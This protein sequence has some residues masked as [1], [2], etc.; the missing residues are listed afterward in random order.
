[1]RQRF[2]HYA[3]MRSMG[4]I[5]VMILALGALAPTQSALASSATYPGTMSISGSGTCSGVATGNAI[6]VAFTITRLAIPI[7]NENMYGIIELHILANPG[8]GETYIAPSP[9][10]SLA[11]GESGTT[12]GTYTPSASEAALLA[13]T[14]TV[15][16]P[17]SLAAVVTAPGEDTWI[18]T[19]DGSVVITGCQD[20]PTATPVTP[21]ATNTVAPTATNT[22]V[23]TATN[24][25]APTSTSTAV[26]TSTNT[27]A[28]T[29]TNTA[30]PTATNTIVPTA[31][32]TIVPTETNTVAPTATTPS[33]TPTTEPTTPGETSTPEPTTPG[34]TP[35]A[36]L[37]P[38][39]TPVVPTAVPT[40]P[41]KPG[42][43]GSTA[44]PV[45]V[46]DLP[47]T[48]QGNAGGP[49]DHLAVALVIGAVILG[50]AGF[51]YGRRSRTN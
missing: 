32:N 31:T 3:F 33:E 4:V 39:A 22:T 46:T 7:P 11:V 1:M 26:P 29:A 47:T 9:L 34:E 10:L 24:T 17:V 28:A 36:T 13:A 40:K 19:G 16:I 30:V 37:P 12:Y 20:M 44:N 35:T 2:G 23:P 41:S 14:G 38:A 6:P 8:V 25:V 5:V 42:Q 48:G 21:T 45:V 43:P 15:T 18:Q 49:N 27:V 51:A 50:A